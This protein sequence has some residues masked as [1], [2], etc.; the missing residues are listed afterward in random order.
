M[1][2]YTFY[3]GNTGQ[4]ILNY[5]GTQIDQMALHYTTLSYIEGSFEADLYYI[6]NGTAASK[7]VKPSKYHEFNYSTKVWEITP[8]KLDFIK[9]RV[10]QQIADRADSI[11]LSPIVYDNKTLDANE[12][13]QQNILGK[14]SQL[15]NEIALNIT[16]TNL[17]WK[18]H[19]NVIHTWT[20][21]TIYLT[22]L[23]G[24]Q[25]AIASRRSSLYSISWTGKTAV[26]AL[27]TYD[28]VSNYS[29]DTLFTGI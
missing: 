20:D 6:E 4:I 16:S 7:L 17:F 10:K 1:N 14:I 19:D 3:D 21:A 24:L 29:I 11:H 9:S 18:D 22:W 23:Q 27:T 2:T 13:A 12:I 28:E 5:S 15:Q 26:D 25:V 8:A